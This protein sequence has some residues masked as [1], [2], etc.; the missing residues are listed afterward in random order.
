MSRRDLESVQMVW[1][2][3]FDY[4]SN[5]NDFYLKHGVPEELLQNITTTMIKTARAVFPEP[6]RIET[7]NEGDKVQLGDYF[8]EVIHTPGHADGHI[9][10][11]CA[12]NG[13]LISG[14]HLLPEITSNVGLWP[15][16]HPNPLECFF[17]SLDKVSKL[18]AKLVI[19]A[20]GDIFS[21]AGQRVKELYVHHRERLDLMAHTASGG[22]TAYEISQKI[23]GTELTFHEI[24]FAISE[25]IA[26]M[27]YLEN[28]KEVVSF[29]EDNVIKYK[30]PI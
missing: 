28:E 27:V 23:F 9:C 4:M 6:P 14:D 15:G 2:A 5:F 1:Q 11:Y 20:H 22:K 7:V 30:N 26:H 24:R 17:S 12:Q 18:G 13:I 21:G 3:G 19:P 25:T 16:S 8:Y 29:T 10:F